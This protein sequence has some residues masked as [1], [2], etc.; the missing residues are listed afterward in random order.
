MN[1]QNKIEGQEIY[2]RPITIEDTENIIRWRNSQRVRR[3]FIYQAQF[4]KE[5]HESWMRNKVATGEVVQ[6]IIC[7][8]ADDR[9]VGSVYFRDIDPV[10]KKAEYGIFIG[11][12]DAA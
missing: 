2:L 10:D 3:N 9:P 11:E 4:T 12:E 6:F 7:Q 1:E 5:G 8:K